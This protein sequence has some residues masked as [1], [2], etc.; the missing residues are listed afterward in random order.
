MD[1][2]R[3]FSTVG[4][5]ASIYLAIRFIRF[6]YLFTRPSSLHR[7]HHGEHPWA[8]VTGASDGIGYGFAQEL[9]AKGF[10]VLLHGRNPAKLEKKKSQLTEEFPNVRFRI[11]VA[12]AAEVSEKQ[13]EDI[14]SRLKDLH[15]TILVNNVGGSSI[16]KPLVDHTFAEMDYMLNVNARFPSQLTR[17]ILPI[18]SKSEEPSLIINIG[19]LGTES[20]I[21]YSVTY[22]C[23]KALNMAF[24]KSLDIELR[25]E[26]QKVDVL[27]VPVGRVTEVVG[28]QEPASLFTPGAGTIVSVFLGIAVSI[29]YC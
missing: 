8:L 10:N 19:S 20:G 28:Y 17:A 13:I 15:I 29:S 12:D 21:P 24:S 4:V 2:S 3:V 22:S 5:V 16:L 25:A 23:C 27:G 14:V 7:Y 6:A 11:I 18:L 26:G 1:A 9:A